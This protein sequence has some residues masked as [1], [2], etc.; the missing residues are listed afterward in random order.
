M[1]ARELKHARKRGREYETFGDIPAGV[2]ADL[3]VALDSEG[4]EEWWNDPNRALGS[5][6]PRACEVWHSRGGAAKVKAAARRLAKR[7]RDQGRNRL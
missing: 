6:P 3:L 5:P 4:C 2:R 1:T 7:A